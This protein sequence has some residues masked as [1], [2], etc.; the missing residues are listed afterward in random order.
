MFCYISLNSLDYT[1]IILMVHVFP[2]ENKPAGTS[3][4]QL[5]ITDEDSLQ[6]GPPFELN[7]LSGNEGGEF[8]LEKDGTLVANQ[9]LRRDRANEYV[10]QIQV[11]SNCILANCILASP[12]FKMISQYSNAQSPHGFNFH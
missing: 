1:V 8:V 11:Y 9:V 6:N 12:P 5:S 2:Q 4:L 3:I 10:L 7:I